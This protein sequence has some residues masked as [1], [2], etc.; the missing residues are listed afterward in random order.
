MTSFAFSLSL[1]ISKSGYSVSF[2]KS[3]SEGCF[4][5]FDLA[6]AAEVEL[7]TTVRV[8]TLD[9]LI[10]FI[11]DCYGVGSFAVLL[12]YWCASKKLLNKSFC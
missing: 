4:L 6:I 9:E 5:L 2:V 1:I 8:L 11:C 10:E 12:R 3:W 7:L